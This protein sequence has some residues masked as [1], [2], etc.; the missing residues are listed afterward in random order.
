MHNAA[1]S[2]SCVYCCSLLLFA[3]RKNATREK[4]WLTKDQFSLGPLQRCSRRTDCGVL[5][6]VG[7]IVL[8]PRQTHK[9]LSEGEWGNPPSCHPFHIYTSSCRTK[10]HASIGGGIY[11]PV[12][13]ESTIRGSGVHVWGII[14][15]EIGESREGEVQAGWRHLEK[16][17]SL[18]GRHGLVWLDELWEFPAQLVKGLV[19]NGRSTYNVVVAQKKT[20]LNFHEILAMKRNN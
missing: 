2:S 20:Y 10:G 17:G 14:C 12:V 4:I 18:V 6:S 16:H 7:I 1:A 13:L 9:K 19:W 11:T 3:R 5:K 15:I 8:H